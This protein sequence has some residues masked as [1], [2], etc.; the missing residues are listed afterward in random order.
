MWSKPDCSWFTVLPLYFHCISL[1]WYSQVLTEKYSITHWNFLS[2][3]FHIGVAQ[4]WKYQRILSKMNRI[5]SFYTQIDLHKIDF[6][7]TLGITTLE[8]AR[9]HK[10]SQNDTKLMISS[11]SR[12]S[13]CTHGYLWVSWEPLNPI[14]TLTSGGGGFLEPPSSS[15]WSTI[16]TQFEIMSSSLVTFNF[17]TFPKHRQTQFLNF[18]VQIWETRVWRQ[19]V[20]IDF[21]KKKWKSLIFSIFLETNHTFSV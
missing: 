11:L 10:S 19:E 5:N 7:I 1:Q 4:I 18:L 20:S 16:S 3:S 21:E 9:R 15:Y 12:R 14:L 6:K 2:F 8:C 17:K 13:Q